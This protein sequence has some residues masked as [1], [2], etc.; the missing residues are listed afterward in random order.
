METDATGDTPG[1][2]GVAFVYVKIG[3]G[4]VVSVDFSP[5]SAEVEAYVS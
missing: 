5:H 1:P 2:D 3:A 4:G